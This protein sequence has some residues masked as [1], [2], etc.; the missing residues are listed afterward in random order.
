MMNRQLR[1]LLVEDNPADADLVLRE[2][3]RAGYDPAWH[4]VDGEAEY[5]EQLQPG[6][7][8]IL[9]DYQ[10]PGF[11]GPRALELRNEHG[12]AM[13]PFIIISGTIGEDLAVEAMK[14]GAADYL[15]KD[16]LA[17]LGL[18]VR[19]AVEK[20][21]MLEERLQDQEELRRTHEEM[22]RLLEHSPAVIYSLRIEDDRG[23]PQNLSENVSRL[24]GFT[25]AEACSLDWWEAHLHPDDKEAIIGGLAEAIA[26]GGLTTEYRLQHRNGD[27]VWLQDHRRVIYNSDGAPVEIAGAWTDISERKHVEQALRAS[28][29]AQLQAAETQT[30]ILNAVSA[31]IALIDAEGVIIAVNEGWRRFALCNRLI[32]QDFCVGRNYIQ[33]CEEAVGEHSQG[34]LEVAR[35]L[36]E[37]LGGARLNFILEYPCHSPTQKRWFRLMATPLRDDRKA[38]AVVMHIDITERKEAEETV[39]E[40]GQR[41]RQLAENIQEVFWI[42]GVP[43][44]QMLYISPAYEAI[45]GRTCDSLYAYP[46]T[47]LA[48]VHPDDRDRVREAADSRQAQGGYH[49]E[50]RIVR[51]GGEIRW[52]RDRAFPVRNAEGEVYRVVGV[53]EDISERKRT[54]DRLREQASLLDKA[55]DAI[56]VRDFEHRV[57]FWNKGAERL[58]GW[59]AEEVMGRP[60]FQL[61]YADVT[62]FD[63]ATNAVLNFGEWTGELRQINKA[64]SP[65]LIEARW[66]LVRNGSGQPHSILA[67]N[68]DITEK[69]RLEQQFLRAQRLESIGTLA[70]GIAHDLNNVLSPIMMSIDLL[71]LTCS[72]QRTESI[73]GT[74]ETSARRGAD[75]VQQILSFARGAEGQ[76][77]LIDPK[78]IIREMQHLVRDTFPKNIQFHASFSADLPVFIGDHTQVHQVLLNLCVNARD[79]MPSGGTLTISAGTLAIDENYAAM[80]LDAKPGAYVEIKVADTGTGIP[81]ELVDKI[82]DPF[83]TTKDLGKG[84]GL[85]LS[86]V[87]A[88]VK[89]HGGFLGVQSEPGLGTTF[90]VCFPAKTSP[91]GLTAAAEEQMHPRGRGELILIVDDEAA[92][93]A[94][95]QQTLE[96]FGYRVLLAGDGAEALSIYAEH[97]EDVAAVLTD[98]MMPIMDGPATIQ[99]LKR[100]NPAVKIIAASGLN[101]DG[102]AAKAAG[103]GVKHFLPKPYTAQTILRTLNNVLCD[104]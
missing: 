60:V 32:G 83:F 61:L 96:A 70:G 55:R 102:S 11:G 71:R 5:L 92:V 21:R 45:W 50:Y 40:S 74:I 81:Q 6:L 62:Q 1:V 38:G 44:G 101:A 47:W 93:R 43:K 65:I 27:Y 52:I 100:M 58:Y 46:E 88:I 26:K 78:E 15:L 80:D 75:M 33:V 82:F 13:I 95:T 42:T 79:A 2:L 35:G 3:R 18:A 84:T 31:H 41:F 97:Q 17:R 59:T 51:P 103:M 10:V 29:K 63:R 4:R 73:L 76:R 53:A 20:G 12:L 104:I 64:G 9:S 37:V 94:I 98:M 90:T 7:D 30:A 23:I 87:L 19:Q 49:E 36:R 67:I 34:A 14:L 77:V 24:L 86:T 48:A 57:T 16:R 56:L 72:D 66:T 91:G 8:I 89:S 54:D 69:K 22:H 68:T 85:G 99:V 25:A 28:E 39:R